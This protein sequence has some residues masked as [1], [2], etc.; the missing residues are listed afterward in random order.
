MPNYENFLTY[1]H[2]QFEAVR[3]MFLLTSA[4]FAAGLVYFLVSS[5]SVSPRYRAS[6]YL[7][8]VVMTSATLELFLL[9]LSWDNAFVY[10]A[11]GVGAIGLAAGQWMPAEGSLFSNGYRYANWCIDVPMLLTQLLIAAGIFGKEFWSKWGQFSFAGIAMIL[12]GYIG[13]FYEPQV[14]G[15]I[16]GPVA[17]F[18]IWGFIST[19]FFIWIV[20]LVMLITQRPSSS[21]PVQAQKEMRL[22]GILLLASWTLYAFGYGWPAWD[23]DAGGV[24]I[25]QALYT[26]A[27]ISSKLLYGVMLGRIAMMR[28]AQEGYLPA[29]ESGLFRPLSMNERQDIA[30]KLPHYA[31]RP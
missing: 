14:A 6:S 28:S 2:W 9:W 13:Q 4:V 25:R 29:I 24:L 21:M 26:I 16:D 30:D 20:V 19:L 5:R 10:E 7:S 18:W 22:I 15:L 8:A 12:T 31:R 11:L 1:E 17:P 27:D 3:H 23:G